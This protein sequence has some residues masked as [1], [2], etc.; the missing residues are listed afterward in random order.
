MART[1]R[2]GWKAVTGDTSITNWKTGEV[3]ENDHRAFNDWFSKKNTCRGTTNDSRDDYWGR[4]KR[5][6]KQITRRKVR[7][8]INRVDDR[9]FDE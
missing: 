9:L 5:G 3:K 8:I 4:D 7:R 6:V 2:I 1:R